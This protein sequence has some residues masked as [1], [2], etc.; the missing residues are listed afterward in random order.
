MPLGVINEEGR[1]GVNFSGGSAISGGVRTKEGSKVTEDGTSID[2]NAQE[3]G[4][5]LR[6]G[7]GLVGAPVG[8]AVGGGVAGPAG[9]FTGM[10]AG[11]GVG[12][13]TGI[14]GN[15]GLTKRESVEE[16]AAGMKK[17]VQERVKGF[18]GGLDVVGVEWANMDT[19][20]RKRRIFEQTAEG[21]VKMEQ[22]RHVVILGIQAAGWREEVDWRSKLK[23][24]DMV[25]VEVMKDGVKQWIRGTITSQR[26]DNNFTIT[27]GKG[28]D[29][30]RR[31]VNRAHATLRPPLDELEAYAEKKGVRLDDSSATSSAT[32]RGGA[33]AAPPST[34]DKMKDGVSGAAA[35]V[36]GAAAAGGQKLRDAFGG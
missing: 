10:V 2:M 12:A 4:M 24:G 6:L 13:L 16:T 17:K 18:G 26:G 30:C 33:K 11:S 23:P 1:K 21:V 32:L 34:M 5:Q 28:D 36:S 3:K 7:G 8:A 22:W 14:G 9:A 25:E 20:M 29:E 35:K 15:V 31:V 19:G 27:Y